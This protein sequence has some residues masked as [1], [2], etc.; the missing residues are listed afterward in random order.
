MLSTGKVRTIVTVI[1][2]LLINCVVV[3]NSLC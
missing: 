2:T 3:T 1:S